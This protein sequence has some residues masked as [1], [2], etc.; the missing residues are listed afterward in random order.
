M[1]FVVGTDEAGY[2]PNLGPLVVAATAWEAAAEPDEVEQAF[3]AAAAKLGGLW[4]DSKRIFKGSG[5]FAALERGALAGV[6]ASGG[7]V[8]DRWG[9]LLA[10]IDAA[11]GAPAEWA[12]SAARMHLPRAGVPGNAVSAAAAATATL[13]AVGVRLVA[14]RCRIVQPREFNTLLAAGANKSDILSQATLDL[15]AALLAPAAGTKV[16]WCDR[17]GGR[18]RYAPLVS[19]ALAAP[20]KGCST[21]IRSCSPACTATGCTSPRPCTRRSCRCRCSR[22]PRTGPRWRPPRPARR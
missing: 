18:R 10:A 5:G 16:V 8:P 4:G 21:R 20:T 22:S 1:T 13:A 7:G 3:A 11:T 14:V 17:H 9:G 12:E 2:G 15:A 6:A 19:R